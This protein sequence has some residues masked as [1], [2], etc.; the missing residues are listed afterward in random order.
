MFSEKNLKEFF[1]LIH[2]NELIDWKMSDFPLQ[3]KTDIMI[4]DTGIYH[5]KDDWLRW[6]LQDIVIQTIQDYF[7][8]LEKIDTSKTNRLEYQEWILMNQIKLRNLKKNLNEFH[9]RRLP[10]N[11]TLNENQIS[12]FKKMILEF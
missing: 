5:M 7:D 11:Q 2:K 6:I 12:L 10:I 9:L 3:F 1:N 4:P 8:L